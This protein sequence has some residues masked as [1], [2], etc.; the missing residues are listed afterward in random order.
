MGS[1]RSGDVACAR[2]VRRH[3]S[4][5]DRST[6]GIDRNG[7]G[8]VPFVDARG[9]RCLASDERGNVHRPHPAN[10]FAADQPH[11]G[12]HRRPGTP[13]DHRASIRRQQP[14]AVATESADFSRVA[15][16]L[17]T[18]L[19]HGRPRS[20]QAVD[21]AAL[22]K[23]ARASEGVIEMVAAVNER[24]SV[25]IAEAEDY[26]RWCDGG[27]DGAPGCNGRL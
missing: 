20:I 8:S 1:A 22:V 19:H 24:L 27:G 18:L 6:R 17:Q 9:R 2:D 25:A 7:S 3:L 15:S 11:V 10:Q 21:V 13:G 5:C 4:L 14:T 12:V 23:L 26:W 16:S